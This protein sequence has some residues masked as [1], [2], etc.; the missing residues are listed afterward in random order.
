MIEKQSSYFILFVFTMY[1]SLS[2][3]KWMII[4]FY[5][6]LI[7]ACLKQSSNNIPSPNAGFIVSTSTPNIPV[8]GLAIINLSIQSSTNSI[9]SLTVS[10]S[11]QL[12][13]ITYNAGA[14]IPNLQSG[15]YLLQYTGPAQAGMQLLNFTLKDQ[16]NFIQF[17]S[18]ALNVM[19]GFAINASSPQL[20][21]INTNDS[22]NIFI[23]IQ[24]KPNEQR[25]YF[26][27]SNDTITY[28]TYKTFSG[29][30]PIPLDGNKIDSIYFIPNRIQNSKPVSIT[31]KDQFDT[32][33]QSILY[34]NIV[35]NFSKTFTLSNS[36]IGVVGYPD[37]FSLSISRI[38]NPNVGLYTLMSSQPILYNNIIYPA[39]IPFTLGKND[40]YQFAYIPNASSTTPFTV[41]FYVTD[42]YTDIT[43]TDSIKINSIINNYTVIPIPLAISSPVNTNIGITISIQRI[44]P[45]LGKYQISASEPISYNSQ[46]YN[47]NEWITLG[48]NGNYTLSFTPAILRQSTLT[49]TV[50]DQYSNIYQTVSIPYNTGSY[51]T[52]SLALV[53]LYNSTNGPN[54]SNNTN[55]LSSSP[56]NTWYGVTIGANRVVK[57]ILYNNN[58]TGTIPISIGN[59]TN[60]VNLL[61][62]NNNLSGSIPDS[63]TNLINLTY[64]YLYNNQLTGGLPLQIGKLNM[65]QDLRIN[66]NLFNAALP[67]SMVNLTVLQTLWIQNNSFTSLPNLST[68]PISNINISNNVFNFV[69][70]F[71]NLANL[72]GNS[73][74][75]APQANVPL[76]PTQQ[77]TVSIGLGQSTTLLCN[78]QRPLGASTNQ[79]QWLKDGVSLGKIG[80]T[81]NL[82]LS[83]I[84]SAQ[85]GMYTCAI[86]NPSIPNLTLT[87][88]SIQVVVQ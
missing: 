29:A 32:T 22:G 57:L 82:V 17:N 7:P 47:K 6:C 66:N 12:N 75:Y 1:K 76:P 69:D 51:N 40:I 87:Q 50:F 63:I 81:Q 54:W 10:Q 42:N 16:K 65:L 9:F 68:T 15:F 21:I 24:G 52:D 31:I 28:H 80:Q 2:Y 55:W 70:I 4:S 20:N 11:I 44:Q 36:N 78:V 27:Y 67:S 85:A 58:L 30:P 60:L 77:P 18:L 45:N 37:S 48:T 84:T 74:A 26:L 64:L 79:Y 59:M 73:T 34:F 49:L 13:G 14:S 8:G 46:N 39:M 61:L 56:I 86:T 43:Q 25:N 53:D 23:S 88:T 19:N 5:I 35:G 72:L 3:Q 41:I 83:N 38:T 62:D 71:P 33:R